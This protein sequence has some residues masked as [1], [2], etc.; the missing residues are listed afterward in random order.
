MLGTVSAENISHVT[1]RQGNSERPCP[2]LL[3]AKGE[4]AAGIR[5]PTAEPKSVTVPACPKWSGQTGIDFDLS[6]AVL[7][8]SWCHQVPPCPLLER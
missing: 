4:F 6:R 5:R 1:L 7:G 3:E 2:I 8:S